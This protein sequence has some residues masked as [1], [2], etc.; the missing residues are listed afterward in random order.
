[1]TLQLPDESKHA[2]IVHQFVGPVQRLHLRHVPSDWVITSAEIGPDA[3]ASIEE[4]RGRAKRQGY[5]VDSGYIVED[6]REITE[7]MMRS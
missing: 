3:T 5:T 1:M 2:R 4:L 7:K 6:W